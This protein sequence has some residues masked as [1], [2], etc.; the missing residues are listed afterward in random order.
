MGAE[1]EHDRSGPGSIKGSVAG[2]TAVGALATTTC[3]ALVGFAFQQDLL[4]LALLAAAIVVVFL[5]VDVGRSLSMAATH[6]QGAQPSDVQRPVVGWVYPLL[7]AI[8]L[9]AAIAI[10]LFDGGKTQNTP[11]PVVRHTLVVPNPSIAVVG[12]LTPAQSRELRKLGKAL[13]GA[14]NSSD[15]GL[16]RL[17]DD[18]FAGAPAA[19]A[20]IALWKG[21]TSGIAKKAIGLVLGALG[22]ARGGG[23]AFR[24]TVKI[25]RPQLSLGG[26]HINLSLGP[27]SPPICTCRGRCSPCPGDGDGGG[28]PVHPDGDSSQPPTTTT[29]TI[30][31]SP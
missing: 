1:R 28:S 21:A 26:L 8:A 10:G 6:V 25:G 31:M 3:A 20:A 22:R 24:T 9:A 14:E 30:P 11:T 4:A 18:L 23:A 17:V 5:L 27:R 19:A 2:G 7:F 29:T 12:A 13:R 15:H 16:G